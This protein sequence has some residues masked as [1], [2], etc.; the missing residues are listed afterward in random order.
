MLLYKR[1]KI[2][3][4]LLLIS[5]CFSDE[6]TANQKKLQNNF[7]WPTSCFSNKH[8]KALGV[9]FSQIEIE[10]QDYI[11]AILHANGFTLITCKD[12]CHRP[13]TTPSSTHAQLTLA[14]SL[15]KNEIIKN[16]LTIA[17]DVSNIET[18]P[19]LDINQFT[20]GVLNGSIPQSWKS[21]MENK[22]FEASQNTYI[23]FNFNN[24]DHCPAY[25]TILGPHHDPIE[26]HSANE[27]SNT[28]NGHN[29]TEH[30]ECNCEDCNCEDCNCE[31]C[32]SCNPALSDMSF[33]ST[34]L[35][36]LSGIAMAFC[37]AFMQYLFKFLQFMWDLMWRLIK[38]VLGLILKFLNY[39]LKR[40]L[41]A[42][43]KNPEQCTQCLSKN[44]AIRAK[45]AKIDSQKMI[46]TKLE[47]QL[48]D[49]A[50][51][52]CTPSSI[53]TKS[54]V[55]SQSS[56]K[57]CQEETTSNQTMIDMKNDWQEKLEKSELKVKQ[58]KENY[59]SLQKSNA[60]LSARCRRFADQLS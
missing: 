18:E 16:T 22:F 10:M 9:L 23:T 8:I 34:L 43:R 39:L 14:L 35:T 25:D 41:V 55:D 28:S 36:W 40:I 31:E 44:E 51:K 24:F 17:S 3:S 15:Q 1:F 49:Q 42:C 20:I 30:E 12:D 6:I 53:Q 56:K 7:L 58:L 47:K 45:D 37:K 2:S 32:M 60:E 59:E 4:L 38:F 19:V 11:F 29:E 57:T 52:P 54:S 33:L 5:L 27:Y 48:H 50:Q 26:D 13:L 21:C 46:I